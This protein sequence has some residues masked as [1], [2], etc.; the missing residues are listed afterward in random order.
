MK[1]VKIIPIFDQAA[2]GIWDS[3]VGLRVNAMR[4]TCNHNMSDQEITNAFQELRSSWGRLKHNFA[5]AAYDG[6]RMVGCIHGDCQKRTAFVRH[7]YVAPEYQH[8]G[9]GFSLLS[10]AE[11]S[12]ALVASKTDIVALPK[13]EKFYQRYGYTSPLKTNNYFKDIK[14]KQACSV[15]P[16]FSCSPSLAKQL[17]KFSP[18]F[19]PEY[20]NQGHCPAF[21][22]CDYKM[23]IGG[24]GFAEPDISLD[25][26][27]ILGRTAMHDD[28]G[29][30]CVSKAFEN[31]SSHI[32]ALCE[33]KNR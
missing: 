33:Q 8:Q 15:V 18:E 29:R 17:A 24:F 27:Q 32:N 2:P 11:H 10:A 30:R 3:F 4:T 23:Q 19:K 12:S 31:L 25:K 16:L 13:A 20:V 26:P 28:W 5:F 21:V 22:Y 9:I 14:G 1:E 6:E 7:L